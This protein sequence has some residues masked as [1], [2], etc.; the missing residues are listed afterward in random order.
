MTV[1]TKDMREALE[2]ARIASIKRLTELTTGGEF[3]TAK[4]VADSLQVIILTLKLDEDA[5]EE[6]RYREA[7]AEREA[8]DTRAQ[9]QLLDPPQLGERDGQADDDGEQGESKAD[10]GDSAIKPG[11]IKKGTK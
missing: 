4:V 7:E 5:Q 3:T 1:L 8:E 9:Q 6:A 2:K 10:D 11:T